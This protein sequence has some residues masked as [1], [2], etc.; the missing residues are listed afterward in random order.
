MSDVATPPKDLYETLR[1]L[2]FCG[3]MNDDQIRVLA[4]LARFVDFPSGTVIF[5]ESDPATHC[6]LVLDGSVLLEIC[7]P[8]K[9]TT[10]LTIGPGE[11][12]GWSTTLGAPRLTATARCLEPPRVIELVGADLLA[13][14]DA[15]PALGYQLM[16]CIAQ[17]LSGRLTATRLQLLDLYGG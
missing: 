4:S 5:S 17:T 16:K 14:C 2:A 15:N 7:G 13:V 12:L 11:L 8:N 9:C 10:I 1:S 6:Y 3:G